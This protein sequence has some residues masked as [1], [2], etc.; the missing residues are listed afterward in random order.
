ML[1]CCRSNMRRRPAG[2]RPPL[3]NIAELTSGLLSHVDLEA[4]DLMTAVILTSAA[5]NRRRRLRLAKALL[6]VY[7]AL[8]QTGSRSSRSDPGTAASSAGDSDSDSEAESGDEAGASSDGSSVH[9]VPASRRLTRRLEGG[10]SE[11][12]R[13]AAPRETV[14]RGPS[15][16]DPGPGLAGPRSRKIVTFEQLVS[17]G[18]PVEGGEPRPEAPEVAI[19]TAASLPLT[20]SNVALMDRLASASVG[21]EESA[22][23]G[24]DDGKQEAA[25]VAVTNEL[26]D[27]AANTGQ[28][29]EAS[30]SVAKGL[31]KLATS[32]DA[33]E[34]SKVFACSQS[35]LRPWETG[36]VI[37]GHAGAS[38]T[39]IGTQPCIQL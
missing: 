20:E 39:C 21:G 4:T 17:P 31:G 9:D 30:E 7:E 2:K 37:F 13:A 35:A 32:V 34:G 28:G 15:R 11:R 25:A 26:H 8:R 18:Q 5:Q 29:G 10:H 1:L 6:P 19:D 33:T 3:S 38:C 27:L 14:P 23:G 36:Y 24:G 12:G 16:F 22:A